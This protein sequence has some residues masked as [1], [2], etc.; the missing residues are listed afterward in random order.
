MSYDTVRR[1]KN[2]F[3]SGVESIKNVPKSGRPKLAYRKEIVSKVKEIIEG[4]VRFTVCDIARKVGISLSTFHLI[5]KKH[6]KVLKI[7]VRWVPHLLTE[8]Q[9]RQQ[10]KVAKRLLQM[11]QFCDKKQFGNVVTGDEN[12]VYY[13][14]PVRKVSNKVWATKHSR[15]P[16]IA[17]R[18][19]SAKKVW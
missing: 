10:V 4:D 18:S 15:R 19:L 13:F 12:W 7:F 1:W 2:K 14:Q 9:N 8:E 6:L 3:E 5:L 11:F 16:I 17:K